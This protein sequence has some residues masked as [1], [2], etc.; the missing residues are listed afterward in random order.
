MNWKRHLR[1]VAGLKPSQSLPVRFVTDRPALVGLFGQ[2]TSDIR[3]L[4]RA[5]SVQLMT[6]ADAEAA[7]VAVDQGTS[8]SGGGM[9][10]KACGYCSAS[11]A[12][13]KTIRSDRV[14]FAGIACLIACLV[15]TPSD[16]P[17]VVG[18]GCLSRGC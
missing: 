7:P 8:R 17:G 9:E 18:M 11:C 12:S 5:E 2:G 1:A 16:K 14:G 15:A 6:P 13:P 10:R 3:S 4:P